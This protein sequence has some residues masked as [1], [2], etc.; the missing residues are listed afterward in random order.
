[1]DISL[2][3]LTTTFH[4]PREWILLERALILAMGLTATLDPYLNPMDIVLPYVE[5][6]VLG[7]GKTIP[8]L[9][10][11]VSKDLITSYINLPHEIQKTLKKMDKGK[12]T[13]QVRGHQ[14][15][16][17]KLSRGMSQLSVTFLLMGSVG[18]SYILFKDGA[19][20]WYEKM[21]WVNGGLGFLWM[22]KSWKNR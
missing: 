11:Q 22:W 4:V 18:F 21:K 13:V 5:Q 1:M 14:E 17:Q 15:M 16:M 9:I 6:T 20:E 8:D 19:L 2:K 10:V 3:E 12:M 7:K